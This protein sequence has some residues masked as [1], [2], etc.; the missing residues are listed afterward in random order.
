MGAEMY[1]IREVLKYE[2]VDSILVELD[3]EMTRVGADHPI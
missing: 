3:P 2:S 1:A